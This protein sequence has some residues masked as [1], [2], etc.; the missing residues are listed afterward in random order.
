MNKVNLVK[1]YINHPLIK[2]IIGSLDDLSVKF[3]EL[4]DLGDI[5]SNAH[6]LKYD[7]IHGSI[8]NDISF[9]DNEILIDKINQFLYCVAMSS[10]HNKYSKT[11]SVGEDIIKHLLKDFLTGLSGITDGGLRD[12][13]NNHLKKIGVKISIDMF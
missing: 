9:K 6:L 13:I 3:N 1:E 7:S 2:I 8:N 11:F 12:M 10:P 4:N 5:K